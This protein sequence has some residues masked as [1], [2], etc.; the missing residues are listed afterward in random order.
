MNATCFRLCHAPINTSHEAP[1]YALFSILPLTYEFSTEH[2]DDGTNLPNC[3]V[4]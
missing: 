2:L 3:T 1:P 4:L